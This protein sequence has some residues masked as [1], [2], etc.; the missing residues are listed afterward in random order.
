MHDTHEEHDGHGAVRLVGGCRLDQTPLATEDR[1]EFRFC[2][3]KV[4]F[5][6]LSG[7]PCLE[8]DIVA[9]EILLEPEVKDGTRGWGIEIMLALLFRDSSWWSIGGAD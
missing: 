5:D 6:R 8:F 1:V 4:G 2:H 7:I 9:L 3:H